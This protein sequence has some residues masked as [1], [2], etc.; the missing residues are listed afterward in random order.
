MNKRVILVSCTNVGRYLINSFLEKKVNSK[1][2]GVINLHSSV[3][4]NKSNYDSYEDLKSNFNL[5][6]KY[7]KNIN[8]NSAIS[9]MESLKPSIII[10]SGWSQKFSEKVLN[11]PKFIT[12]GQHPAPLPVGRGAACV[13]WAIIKGYK[14]WGD[15]FFQMDNKYDNGEI[16][17]QKKFKICARDDVKTIY[18]KVCL[19]SSK[20]LIENVDKWSEGKFN[21][22]KQN[23]K[24]AIYFKKRN[25]SDGLINFNLNKIQIHNLI[26]A[27]TNPYPGAFFNIG[28]KKITILKSKINFK[29]KNDLK[30]KILKSKKNYFF[31]NDGL[32]LKCG[33]KKNQLLKVI[34]LKVDSSP[35]LWANEMKYL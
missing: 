34:R 11:I 27:L 31:L 4:I 30:N 13:N 1:L 8:Q 26:R 25:P 32:Y 20:I 28:K 18:D 35:E 6:I 9:W 23:L 22:K 33:L 14:N 5:N 17:A 16:L 7:V 2:V 21:K 10:Q 29:I 24:N 15:T 19:T 12:I 3:A